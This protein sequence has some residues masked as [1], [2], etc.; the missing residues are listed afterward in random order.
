[1]FVLNNEIKNDNKQDKV[2]N[3]TT[4]V[5]IL[6]RWLADRRV[7]REASRLFSASSY[8]EYLW[9]NGGPQQCKVLSDELNNRAV[10]MLREH[11]LS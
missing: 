7:R 8:Q 6:A 10:R 11:G 4:I 1:M 5:G 3:I 9:T 2:M